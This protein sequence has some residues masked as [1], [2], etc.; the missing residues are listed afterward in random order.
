MGLPWT[1][2]SLGQKDKK[3]KFGK[4]CIWLFE[5]CPSLKSDSLHFPLL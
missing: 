5:F 2:L 1:D 3:I 4:I